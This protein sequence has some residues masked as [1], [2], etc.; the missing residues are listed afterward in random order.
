VVA[1]RDAMGHKWIRMQYRARGAECEDI[2][3]FAGTFERAD[4]A[5][6]VR[7]EVDGDE[8]VVS[9]VWDD[10]LGAPVLYVHTVGDMALDAIS[11]HVMG[12]ADASAPGWVDGDCAAVRSTGA[13]AGGVVL[14]V[15]VHP[16]TGESV[17][18]IHGCDGRRWVE[19]VLGS[20][21]GSW[22]L[23]AFWLWLSHF[24]PCVSLVLRPCV[25]DVSK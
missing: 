1:E 24:A 8:W 21:E 23:P 11:R 10:M 6:M 19:G 13:G 12:L 2:E 25:S 17:L 16:R 9:V 4:D 5:T 14:S 15:V 3:N 22:T 20:S 18:S 7:G